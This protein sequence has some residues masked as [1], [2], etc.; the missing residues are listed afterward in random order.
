MKLVTECCVDVAVI[1]TD[2]NTVAVP[3]LGLMLTGK[4]WGYNYIEGKI[5]IIVTTNAPPNRSP[6]KQHRVVL[7][8]TKI[9]VFVGR[10]EKGL[11]RT[12]YLAFE[13]FLARFLGADI[14]VERDPSLKYKF[15]SLSRWDLVRINF[16]MVIHPNKG[17][18]FSTILFKQ[19]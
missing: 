10:L 16:G 13:L 15:L 7:K 11:N 12:A 3:F 1:R 9:V 14:V 8:L 6:L 17:L 19:S 5:Q 4:P 2:G 18:L